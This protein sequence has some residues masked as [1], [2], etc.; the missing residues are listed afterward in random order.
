MGMLSDICKA[1]EAFD[2]DVDRQAQRAREDPKVRN[3]LLRRWCD[4]RESIGSVETPTGLSLPRL[5]LPDTEEP[6]EVARYLLGEGLPGEFPFTNGA[7]REMYLEQPD[8]KTE[9]PTRLF[10]GLGLAEDTNARFQFLPRQ[11]QSAR[12]ST[13]FDGPTLY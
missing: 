4:A 9:E 8:H 11:Q 10:A 5:A 6:G 3:E 7:Y 1:A 13:A 12:L 2:R